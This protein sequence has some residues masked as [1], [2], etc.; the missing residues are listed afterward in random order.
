[1]RALLLLAAAASI[2]AAQTPK[3]I[4]AIAKDGPD[5]IPRLAEY[6][7]SQDI[8]VRREVARQIAQLG[9]PRALDP[10]I[11]ATADN[12]A[13]VQIWATDGLVNFYLPGYL[14][15]GLAGSL[16]RV[17]TALR[18]RFSETNDQVIDP[19]VE[20]RVDVVEAIGKLARGGASLEARANA[21]RAA[22]ILRGR[23]AQPYLLEA[24]HSKDSR[25]LYESL[26]AFQKIR[27][28]QAAPEIGAK[29]RYLLRDLDERV[30]VTAIE[31][32][33]LIQYREALPELREVFHRAG[34]RKKARRAALTAIAMMPDPASREIFTANL[35]EKDDFF[36]AACAEGLG[37]IRNPADIKALEKGFDDEKSAS[38]RLSFAFALVAHGRTEVSEFSPLQ[39]LINN[40]N[41]KLHSGEAVPLLTELARDAAVR[42]LLYAQMPAGTKDEKLGLAQILSRSGAADSLEAL[43]QLSR[44]PDRDVSGEA[45][46]ALRSIRARG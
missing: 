42:K 29:I 13:E 5:A 46:R 38:A 10:L 28:P 34:S 44:D 3:D 35:E 11:T 15:T 39:I 1:M 18:S 9:T 41:S 20:T 25:V 24:V 33:G 32:I 36:R 12:D 22:G 8:D 17:G 26:I 14:Q 4:R 30:Q 40:L 31:T 37:R 2:A 16:R 43:E 21:A 45:L 19:G 7:R 23:A 27:D 6:F